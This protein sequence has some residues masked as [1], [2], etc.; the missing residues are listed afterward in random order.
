MD[1]DLLIVGS[2]INAY[3]MARC[4]NEAYNKKA[5][6]IGNMP[7]AVT[8]YSKILNFELVQDLNSTTVFLKTLKDFYSEHND[9]KILLIGSTNEYVR[10]IIENKSELHKYFVFHDNDEEVLNMFLIKENFFVGFKDIDKRNT[11]IYDINT[12]L[13]MFKINEIGYP[14][15]IRLGNEIYHE[16]QIS[17][18]DKA[19]IAND[20]Y[21]LLDSISHI[22]N[23]GYKKNLIIQKQLENDDSLLFDCIS[24][25]DRRGKVVL[26]SFAQIGLQEYNENYIGN[27][28]VIVN[29]FNEYEGTEKVIKNVKR[30]LESINYHGFIHFKFLYNKEKDKYEVIEVN[31]RQARSSYYLSFAGYN[32]VEYLVND[33]IYNKNYDYQFVDKKV[34][35]SFVSKKI[36]NKCVKSK[37]LKREIDRL[38]K[39]KQYVNPIKNKKDNTI[40]R[41]LWLKANDL[42]YSK[43][44]KGGAI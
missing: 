19:Y 41:I 16:L 36:I 32:L 38:Y 4:Y 10:L 24:Y 17:N 22:R 43:I 40:K 25:V 42:N 34:C 23:S 33:L 18:K 2:D 6:L 44:Y 26:T 30:T 11:Y 9:K 27:A 5:Y 20:I 35:L 29:G 13:N 28:T 3:Y 15:I 7:M 37:K 21:E 1:F 39:N 8:Y 31:P 12:D 14:I